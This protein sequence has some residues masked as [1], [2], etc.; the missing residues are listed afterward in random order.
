MAMSEADLLKATLEG[1][2]F[3]SG[4]GMSAAEI[5][6]GLG[7]PADKIRIALDSLVDDYLEREGGLMIQEISGRYQF[8]TQPKIYPG[9][10]S[11][12]RQKKKDTLSKSLLETLAIITYK[13]PTTLHEIEDIRGVASRSHVAALMSRKLVK[14]MGQKEAPGKPTL[15]GTTREFL[16][17]FGLNNL[18]ELP[19]PSDIKELNFEEL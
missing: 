6:T 1:L 10:Q 9:I 5:S 4:S 15:Y 19:P 8:V 13:Q 17:Y 14:T 2:L 16:T 12:L 18:E 11:F 3:I 7:E